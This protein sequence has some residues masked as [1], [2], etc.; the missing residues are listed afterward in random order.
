M[1]DKDTYQLSLERRDGTHVKLYLVIIRRH[2]ED[3]RQADT[4]HYVFAENE[5]GAISQANYRYEE[6]TSRHT[7]TRLPFLL[8]GW[9]K[10]QF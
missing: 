7:A 6:N 4:I 5:K 10:N 8:R 3:K 9:A 1:E 2:E